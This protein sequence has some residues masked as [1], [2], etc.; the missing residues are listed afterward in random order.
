MAPFIT[1]QK[2]SLLSVLIIFSHNYCT[3]DEMCLKR[4]SVVSEMH[5]SQAENITNHFKMGSERVSGF[6]ANER[7]RDISRQT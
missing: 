6:T 4:A 2:L 1:L 3:D 5:I 7:P